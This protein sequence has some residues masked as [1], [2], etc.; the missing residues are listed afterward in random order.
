MGKP[1]LRQWI[2]CHTCPSAARQRMDASERGAGSIAAPVFPGG[3]PP[4]KCFFCNLNAVLCYLMRGPVKCGTCH[5]LLFF[6][7]ERGGMVLRCIAE[8]SDHMFP[9]SPCATIS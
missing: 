1:S 4:R 9:F 3:P 5:N 7:V 6:N 8:N 2:E